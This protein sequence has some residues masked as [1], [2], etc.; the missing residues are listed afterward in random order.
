MDDPVAHSPDNRDAN[1][2]AASGTRVAYS[3]RS[4]G[5]G[6]VGDAGGNTGGCVKHCE[7]MKRG[8]ESDLET[9]TGRRLAYQILSMLLTTGWSRLFQSVY[10]DAF[11]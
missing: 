6:A 2:V 11:R 5:R 10:P 4:D 1:S 8:H 7:D 9:G 3:D